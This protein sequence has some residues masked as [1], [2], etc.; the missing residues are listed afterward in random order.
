MKLAKS[1]PAAGQKVRR[2]DGR[3]GRARP[4]TLIRNCGVLHIYIERERERERE[5][6]RERERSVDLR[7]A[8]EC[9]VASAYVMA[10]EC[11]GE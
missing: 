7:Q 11:G 10:S 2:L 1:A 6:E 9:V 8:S 3:V 5:K 4:L